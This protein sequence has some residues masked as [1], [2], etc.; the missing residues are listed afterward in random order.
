MT[1]VSVINLFDRDSHISLRNYI[2]ST[3]VGMIPGVAAMALFSE[4]VLALFTQG[5]P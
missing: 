5:R 2:I 3:S 4:E 1:P